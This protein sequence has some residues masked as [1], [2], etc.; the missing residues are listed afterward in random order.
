MNQQYEKRY[1]LNKKL[2]QVLSSLSLLGSSMGEYSQTA[3]HFEVGNSVTKFTSLFNPS[4][5]GNQTAKSEDRTQSSQSQPL[6]TTYLEIYILL[7]KQ[8][9]ELNKI[10]QR[11]EYLTSCINISETNIKKIEKF[12]QK[13]KRFVLKSL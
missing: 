4:Q 1:A 2:P 9:Q 7:H 3:R 8:Q 12:D 10:L 13:L 6:D 11:G 5:H